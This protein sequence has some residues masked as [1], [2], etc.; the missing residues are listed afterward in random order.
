MGKV[1][2]NITVVNRDDQ[3]RVELGA[4]SSDRVRQAAVEAL[5]DTGATMLALP[6]EIIERLG[7]PIIRSAMVRYANGTVEEKRIASG[8]RVELLGRGG[9]FDALVESRGTT[10]LIGQVILGVLDLL[11][12]PKSG[13]LVPNPQSPDLPTVDLL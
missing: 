1:I 11:V 9:A 10:P 7:L 6:E 13:N 3:I 8:I 2:A 12:D 4:L 5:V